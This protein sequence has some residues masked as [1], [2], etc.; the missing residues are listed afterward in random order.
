LEDLSHKQSK[1]EIFQCKNELEEMF[2]VKIKDFCYPFGKFN[3]THIDMIKEAGYETAT[4]MIRGRATTTS[5]NLILPRI[6]IT[7]RTL[8][9]LFLAKILTNYEDKREH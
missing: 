9:H 4:T 7:N 6:P 8:P 3:K 5:H 1:V 2:Q